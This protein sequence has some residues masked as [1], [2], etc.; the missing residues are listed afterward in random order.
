MIEIVERL[1]SQMLGQRVAK[2]DD[3]V[4]VIGAPRGGEPGL[5]VVNR[6]PRP[7]R[8]PPVARIQRKG[9]ASKHRHHLQLDQVGRSTGG[10]GTG[11][12]DLDQVGRR[13]DKRPATQPARPNPPMVLSA[14]DSHDPPLAPGEL[15][16]GDQPPDLVEEHRHPDANTPNRTSGAIRWSTRCEWRSDW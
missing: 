10:L 9:D 5:E 1:T 16:V 3:P 14:D 13:L 2:V 6:R 4:R 11:D 15:G 12:E 8:L 7:R